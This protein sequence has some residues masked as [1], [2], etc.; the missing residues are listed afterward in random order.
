MRWRTVFR[1]DGLQRLS[2]PDLVRLADL[3]IKTVLDL[4]TAIEL[5]ERGRIG[6]VHVTYH[7][8][9]VI[10]TMWDRDA[11]EPGSDPARYLA[12]RYLEMLDEGRAALG[13]ALHH[14]RQ[15]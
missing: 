3:G 14:H 13:T 5:E 10:Q 7:H 15:H 9:P 1:A 2:E 4:R 6:A 11:Y 8:L 12:D